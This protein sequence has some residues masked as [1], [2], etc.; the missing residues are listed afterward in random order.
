MV[1]GLVSQHKR[2]SATLAR[3]CAHSLHWLAHNSPHCGEMNSKFLRDL[4]V[5]VGPGLVTL[6]DPDRR[7]RSLPGDHLGKSHDKVRQDTRCATAG[8]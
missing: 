2:P 8:P 5:A 7:Q 6:C 3:G 1:S 4:L